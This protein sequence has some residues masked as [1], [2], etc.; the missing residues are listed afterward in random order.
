MGLRTIILKLHK[1][2]KSKQM[3]LDK[4]ITNY[5]IAF[6]FLLRKAYENL[7]E[8]Q[9]RLSGNSSRFT[10]F[11]LSKWIDKKTL[12]ELN[13][14]D[15]QPFKDSLKLDF[16]MTLASY[17]RLK[18]VEPEVGFPSMGDI[19]AHIGSTGLRP[20]YFCR[21]DTMRCYC[22]L[23]DRK[24]DRYYVKLYLANNRNAKTV[25]DRSERC[26]RLVYIHKEGGIMENGRRKESFIIVPLSFGKWQEKVLKE[27]LERPECLRTAKLYKKGG[28]YYLAVSID[29]GDAASIK[30][31]N[32]MGISRGLKNKLNY[33]VVDQKGEL[34][35]QGTIA[36]GN[37]KPE[38]VMQQYKK[39]LPLND[40]HV[41]ANL[42][43]DIAVA[44]KAQVIVQNLREKGDGIT[45]G[46]RDKDE[47]QAEYK[48]EIRP[49][50]RMRDYNR[51]TGLLDYK[52]PGQGLPPPVKVSSVDIFAT[53]CSCGRNSKSNRS[54]K[55]LFICVAC[56]AT[57]EIEK[58]GSLNLAK[59]LIHYNSSRI[60]IKVTRIHEGIWFTN[61]LLGLDL[62]SSY[63][64]DQR[65]MLKNEISGIIENIQEATKSSNR[66]TKTAKMSMVKKL[67][68]AIDFM[69]VLEYI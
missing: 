36:D 57:M 21:Y 63:Q 14:Y 18:E 40:L 60:K 3:L 5:N 34:L 9:S 56:G 12:K 11:A 65:E 15:V 13:E 28:A 45:W 69:D 58:L 64:E 52:L 62:F 33:T 27:A 41:D 43:T 6:S 20:I 37:R 54:M 32:Y 10:T 47:L 67:S 17:L 23:Y 31:I 38:A 50:Y 25:P 68:G 61:K 42:I 29:T 19:T 26:G 48:Q 24:K 46:I 51:L 4:A 59:K 1:P 39:G 44:S 55:D 7:E 22:L 8:I 53:C 49:E 66:R 16:G 35:S 2:G 30:T